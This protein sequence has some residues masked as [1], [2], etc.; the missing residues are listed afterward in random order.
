MKTRASPLRRPPN[1]GKLCLGFLSLAAALL[2]ASQAMA[3]ARAQEGLN[4]LTGAPA[5]TRCFKSVTLAQELATRFVASGICPQ[6]R[7]MDPGQ[8]LRALEAQGAIDRDFAGDAC[9]LQFGLMFR[10]GRE[11]I[12]K[13]T[14]GSCAETLAKLRKLRGTDIFRGL[15]R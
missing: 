4:E 10:A 8:F 3:Q 9:Q 5:G 2:M 13:D 12:G 1:H 11:W 15:V 6:L 14:N 7:P